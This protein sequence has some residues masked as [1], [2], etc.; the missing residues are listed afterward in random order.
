MPLVHGGM[1][2]GGMADGD[3]VEWHQ[4][5]RDVED[6]ADRVD[7][8]LMGIKARP[9]TAQ[10]D[11]MGRQQDVLGCGREVLLPQ[12]PVDAFQETV[13]V[14]ADHDGKGC[15]SGHLGVRQRVGELRQQVTVIDHD[16]LPRLAVHAARGA[17]G[18]VEDGGDFRVGHRGIGVAS[19]ADAAQDIHICIVYLELFRN[20]IADFHS[21]SFILGFM[22]ITYHN[23]A[24]F[25]YVTT[26]QDMF[27]STNREY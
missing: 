24:W 8:L 13:L 27:Y 1:E 3:E 9:Y 11:G 10:A 26:A 25:E 7:A 18:G 21:Q 17:H 2:G 14:A 15:L 5:G 16:E 19:H 23:Q 6:P 4:V 20:G 12:V 22:V